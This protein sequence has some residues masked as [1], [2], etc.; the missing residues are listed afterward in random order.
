[1]STR[2]VLDSWAMLALLQKENPATERVAELMRKAG[3]N[4]VQLAMSLINL[5]EVFYIFGRKNGA[6]TAEE[7]LTTIQKLP[8]QILPAAEHSVFTAARYRM[9]NPIS[10]ADAFAVAAAKKLDAVLLTG[11]PEL[12][13]LTEEIQIERLFT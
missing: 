5:G 8:I 1:M 7:L 10:Y 2:F 4:E 9:N 6:Q 13:S 11:D 12:L 3:Q